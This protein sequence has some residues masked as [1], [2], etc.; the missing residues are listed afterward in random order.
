MQLEYD[1][2]SITFFVSVALS[3]CLY[4]LCV[5]WLSHDQYIVQDV[6]PTCPD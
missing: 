3:V 1:K 6:S 4:L 2:R 5:M